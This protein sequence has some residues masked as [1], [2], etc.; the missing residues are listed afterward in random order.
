MKSAH[1]DITRCILLGWDIIEFCTDP[2]TSGMFI[3]S[4]VIASGCVLIGGVIQPGRNLN[5]LSIKFSLRQNLSP[6]CSKIPQTHPNTH[7]KLPKPK[8][9][10]NTSQTHPK[11][12][13][14]TPQTHTHI[15][16]VACP[17]V[18]SVCGGGY[19]PHEP[20]TSLVAW[21]LPPPRTL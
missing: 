12:T 6:R 17:D 13:P 20:V 10:P 4:L 2:L 9:I 11:H 14:N 1:K 3:S 21:Q 18:S 16:L 7:P 8:L 19:P 15:A 5:Y